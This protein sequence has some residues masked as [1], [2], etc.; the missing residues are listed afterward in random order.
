MTKIIPALNEYFNINLPQSR[1][2]TVEVGYWLLLFQAKMGLTVD[3]MVGGNTY[4][5]L[6]IY[7]PAPHTPTNQKSYPHNDSASMKRYYGDPRN[8]TKNLVRIAF[9]YSMRLAW[10]TGVKVSGTRVHKEC[11]DSFE[12]AFEAILAEYG[13]TQIQELGLDLF[14]G[15]YNKRRMR[16]GS[17][18]STHAYGCAIDLDPAHNRFRKPW[19]QA[20]FSKSEYKP[21]LTIMKANGFKHL[22]SFDAMHFE[23]TK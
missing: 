1:T 5:K 2:Y 22:K 12:S 16:G 14:G 19:S 11:K 6:S 10:D 9:P 7:M 13:L 4:S 21:F 23:L 8:M 18:W 15:V 17:S 3:G 20:R